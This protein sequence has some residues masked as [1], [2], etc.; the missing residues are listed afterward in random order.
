MNKLG[1]FKLPDLKAV[2]NVANQLKRQV[3]PSGHS[4]EHGHHSGQGER[5][6]TVVKKMVKLNILTC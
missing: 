4:D 3:F 6:R 2:G 5:V 1:G